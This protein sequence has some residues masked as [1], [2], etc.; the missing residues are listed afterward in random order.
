MSPYLKLIGASG[1]PMATT[2]EM[3]PL[4]RRSRLESLGKL[5][6]TGCD[7]LNDSTFHDLCRVFTSGWSVARFFFPDGLLPGQ[8]AQASFRLAL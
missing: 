5:A 4:M 8:A 7:S 1:I 2:A 6:V 3:T